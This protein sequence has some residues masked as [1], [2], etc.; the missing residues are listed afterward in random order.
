MEGSEP[1]FMLEPAPTIR[2]VP[3][4]WAEEP[5]G[6][7]YTHQTHGHIFAL[8][9]LSCHERLLF[10]TTVSHLTGGSFLS[11]LDTCSPEEGCALL[12]IQNL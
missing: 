9:P 7:L 11:P 8:R 6:W 2:C 5:G 4:E 10:R 1:L 12:A 3:C